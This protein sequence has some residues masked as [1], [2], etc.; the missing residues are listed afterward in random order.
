MLPARLPILLRRLVR[1]F[2]GT[3][4]EFAKSVQVTEST[5]SHLLSGDPHYALGIEP[6]LRI[7]SVTG[8][9]ASVVLRAAGKGACADLL[10]QLYGDPVVVLP[11]HRP[12]GVTA[13]DVRLLQQ[14]RA[15]P[16]KT[17]RAIVV[18]VEAAVT[19]TPVVRPKPAVRPKLVNG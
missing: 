10:E 5:L 3:R 9:S 12:K 8:T 19:G 15:L 17:Q 7:A 11:A 1:E 16:P 18:L 4:G 6:C 2:G 14:W 13:A